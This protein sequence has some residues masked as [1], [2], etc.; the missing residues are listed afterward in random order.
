MAAKRRDHKGQKYYHLT[1]LY[2]TRSGGAGKGIYWMARCDCGNIREVRGSEAALGK[3]KSCGTC[4]YHTDMLSEAASAGAKLR[5]WTK[6][7][8]VQH[9]RYI[10]SAVK[11]GIEWRLSPEEFLTITKK[12]CTYCGSPPRI[13]ESKPNYGKGRTVK[14]LMNGID[15]L[16]S[17][18][19]Y[20]TGNVV[21]CCGTCN[22]M[23][24]AMDESL[25]TIHVLKIAKHYLEKIGKDNL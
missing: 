9:L 7:I 2:P 25:F 13:Y 16:D 24:M 10:K 21:P 23:K 20:V 4:K 15:R 3:I 22:K 6:S 8:R 14:T 19:G 11:R 17:S 12:D 5:G 18:L 1:L